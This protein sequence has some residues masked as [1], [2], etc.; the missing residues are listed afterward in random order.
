MD[1]LQIIQANHRLKLY[2]QENFKKSDSSQSVK[3]MTA[4][5]QA[6]KG[7]YFHL[8][9]VLQIALLKKNIINIPPL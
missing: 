3:N 5:L 9:T 8:F 7:N 1:H 4:F 6:I 2:H